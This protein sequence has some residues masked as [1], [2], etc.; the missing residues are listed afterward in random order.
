[1]PL[2][3]VE[4]LSRSLPLAVLYQSRLLPPSM[5]PGQLRLPTVQH[6]CRTAVVGDQFCITLLIELA[7]RRHTFADVHR[8]AVRIAAVVFPEVNVATFIC[9]A[10]TFRRNSAE[11]AVEQNGFRIRIAAGAVLRR[12]RQRCWFGRADE[13]AILE[14]VA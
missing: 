10:P 5:C 4:S 9:R 14:H 12:A 13:R 11:R 2:P 6:K 3:E 8:R 7:G 1:M